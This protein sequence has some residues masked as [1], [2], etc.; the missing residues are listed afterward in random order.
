MFISDWKDNLKE[1][2]GFEPN[3][4]WTKNEIG[5]IAQELEEVIPQAVCRA[6][7]DN[8]HINKTLY[9]GKIGRKDGETVPYKNY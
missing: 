9:D 1:T 7:F 5:M 4:D 8:E 3:K 2:V 6:P